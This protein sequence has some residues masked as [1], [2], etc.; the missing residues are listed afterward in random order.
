MTFLSKLCINLQIYNIIKCSPP[1]PGLHIRDGNCQISQ[2][3]LLVV[4][5]IF[6]QDFHYMTLRKPGVSGELV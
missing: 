1:P 5:V 4:V 3:I 6:I 2:D